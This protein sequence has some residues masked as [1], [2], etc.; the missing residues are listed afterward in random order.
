VHWL[1]HVWNAR[2]WSSD[3]GNAPEDIQSTTVKLIAA[4]L[5]IPFVRH[6][7]QREWEKLH[8]HLDHIAEKTGIE[9]FVAIEAEKWEHWVVTLFKRIF[10]RKASS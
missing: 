2:W 10:N 3:L 5:L 1:A 6:A 8:A 7:W 4:S 9:P